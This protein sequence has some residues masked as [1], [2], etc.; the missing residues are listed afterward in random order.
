MTVLIDEELVAASAGGECDTVR[1]LLQRGSPPDARNDKGQSALA[2]AASRN[3]ADVVQVL[4]DHGADPEGAGADPSPARAACT[5]MAADALRILLAAG[6]DPESRHA[7][8]QSLL[9]GVFLAEGTR[10][11]RGYLE[12]AKMLLDAG[13]SIDSADGDGATPLTR[14]VVLGRPE[15]VRWLLDRGADPNKGGSQGLSLLEIAKSRKQAEIVRLLT[16]A[17]R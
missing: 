11:D 10:R 4:L 9:N 6:A 5:M 3:H 7:D 13:A 15:S 1:D 17:S 16:A 2:M 14:A 8:G 12:L